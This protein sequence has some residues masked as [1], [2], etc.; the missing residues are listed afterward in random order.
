MYAAVRYRITNARVRRR[1]LHQTSLYIESSNHGAI[2]CE[3]TNPTDPHASGRVLR[4]VNIVTH[5]SIY[6]G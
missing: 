3:M 4:R 2:K 5:V 6:T 1:V